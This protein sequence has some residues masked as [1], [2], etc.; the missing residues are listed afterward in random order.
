M[1]GTWVFK[2]MVIDKAEELFCNCDIHSYRECKQ[3]AEA[4]SRKWIHVHWQLFDWFESTEAQ[5]MSRS[6]VCQNGQGR[7]FYV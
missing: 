3:L 1:E 7:K 4:M 5:R 2:K 6:V